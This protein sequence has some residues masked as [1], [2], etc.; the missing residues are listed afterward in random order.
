MIPDTGATLVNFDVVS[1]AMSVQ[2]E[3]QHQTV[4]FAPR[5]HRLLMVLANVSQD[6]LALTAAIGIQPLR[7]VMF[8]ALTI[9]VHQGL[10]QINV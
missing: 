3:A 8:S 7:D 5:M 10:L 2:A 6:G 1:C 4:P 9:S